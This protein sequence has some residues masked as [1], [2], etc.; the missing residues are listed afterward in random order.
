MDI[1]GNVE[2]KDVISYSGP[3]RWDEPSEELVEES[4]K[5]GRPIY[6]VQG[7]PRI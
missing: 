6:Y 3:K 7:Q 5:T 2:E 4:R 1:N